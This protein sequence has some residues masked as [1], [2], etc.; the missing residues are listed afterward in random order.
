MT[1]ISANI[2]LRPTRIG[3][4]VQPTD[5]SS[6]RKIMRACACLWGGIYNP[7]IPV[8]R[9]PPREW[10]SKRFERVKGLAIAKGYIDFFE[11]DVFVESKHGLAEE[12]GLGALLEKHTFNEHVVPLSNTK[13]R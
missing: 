3:F 9:N 6:V 5:L 7:I 10:R 13:S 1:E 4:L 8:F 11:P 2:R 12:A